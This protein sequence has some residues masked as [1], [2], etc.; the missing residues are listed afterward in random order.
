MFPPSALPFVHSILTSIKALK[1][2]KI[3]SLPIFVTTQNR[4][5]LGDTIPELREYIPADLL[6]A[7]ADKSKFSMWVPE[8]S[9]HFQS[10]DSPD[11]QAVAAAAAAAGTGTAAA[12]VNSKT[13]IVVVGI[14]SHI[15]VTQTVLDALAAGHRVYV[16][17]DGVSSCNREEV[18]V[19]LARLRAEGAVITTSE[20]WLYECVG[21]A[22]I[23]EFKAIIGLVKES[24]ADTRTALQSLLAA[25]I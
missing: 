14:E 13:T 21:D 5:R 11:S 9:S 23:P 7:D 15:C 20:S 1:A 22:A 4:A 3:L 10:D 6:R 25:K 17:A 18:P 16:L 8:V 19:A 12:A 2:A 24:A